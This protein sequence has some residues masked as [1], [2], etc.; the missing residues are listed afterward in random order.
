MRITI[1]K[2]IP[3]AAGMA[4]RVGRRRGDAAA[5]RAP[6]RAAGARCS[7]D[8]RRARGR[9]ARRRSRPARY[10]ATGAGEE[11][12]PLPTA[13][14]TVSSCCPAPEP[15]S[16]GA[17]FR[18][19]DRLGLPRAPRRSRRAARR[20]ASRAARELPGA[21][22]VNDLEPAALALLPEIGERAG[23][24]ARGRR[25]PRPG[26]AAAA[27]P[28]SG[29]FPAIPERAGR[30]RLAGAA[31][32]RSGRP[33]VFAAALRAYGVVAAASASAR[34]EWL[35][36]RLGRARGGLLRLRHRARPPAE[37]REPHQGRRREARQVD[38]PARRRDGV[39]RDRRVRRAG[40]PGRVHDPRRRRRRGPGPHRRHGADRARLG[41]RRRRRPHELLPRPPARPRVHGAPRPEGQD[42][43]RAARAGRGLLRPPRRQGDP[44]RALRRA[45]PRDRAVPRGLVADAAAALRPLRRRRRRP[46]GHDVRASSATSSGTASTRSPRSRRRAR[47][48][49]GSRSRS[50]F[51]IYAAVKWLRVEA[52]RRRALSG[53]TT[54]RCCARCCRSRAASRAR[55]S[56]PGTA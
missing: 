34:G 55:S 1:G 16:T 5:A 4:R 41:V 46:L 49:W 24:G 33:L 51:G 52:N 31:V 48:R 15:L 26:L 12:E 3:V 47:W 44:D 28:C 39:P 56:S 8:R 25:R 35:A 7:A 9:R 43:A 14:R 23:A 13:A 42:H 50:A 32:K 29:L 20:G 2:R 17:V 38:V 40:R 36:R 54:S 21:L 18:Q 22:A 19:A 30:R 6:Q 27:R 45:R 53:S 11:V 10:L 37:H